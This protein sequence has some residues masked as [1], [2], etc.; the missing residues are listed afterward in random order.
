[1]TPAVFEQ[2]GWR[3]DWIKEVNEGGLSRLVGDWPAQDS[4]ADGRA[5]LAASGTAKDSA[6]AAAGAAPTTISGLRVVA[7]AI[8]RA[9]N[10]SGWQPESPGA[11]PGPGRAWRVVPAGSVFWFELPAGSDIGNPVALWGQSL[12]MGHWQRDGWGRCV[13]GVA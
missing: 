1:V 13:V 5:V 12:C 4:V 3:P 6:P 7:A 10:W 9:Q 8:M 2:G 11:R